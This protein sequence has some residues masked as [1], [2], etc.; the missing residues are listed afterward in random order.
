[1]RLQAE[2]YRPLPHGSLGCSFTIFAVS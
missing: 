2:R 1:V